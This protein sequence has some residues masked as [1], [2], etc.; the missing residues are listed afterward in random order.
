[1]SYIFRLHNEGNNALNDWGNSSK[2]AKN[3]ID[4]IQDPNGESA[5]REITSI[6]SP[7]ARIDLVKTAFGKVAAMGVDG[8]TIYHKM[9][10]D[11]LDV[12]Q[13]F[14]EFDKYADQLEILVWDKQND[15]EELLNSPYPEHQQLGKTYDIFLKQDGNIYNFDQ[16]DRMYLLNFKNGP[17]MTNIIGATSPATLFF[18]S[19]ND[20]SYV[21]NA[22]RLS[23]ND[24]PFDDEWRPLYQ[25]DLEYQKFWYLMQK[26][27]PNFA[28]LFPE[29]NNYLDKSFQK[30]TQQEQQI[31][32]AIQPNDLANYSD[33]TVNGSAGNIVYLINGISMKQK[34]QNTGNIEQQSGFV[35]DSDYRI[36]GKKPLVLPIDIY[37]KPTFYISAP[38]DRNTVVPKFDS[39]PVGD[40]QLPDSDKYPYL[41]I[42]DFLSDTIVRMPYE[43]NKERFFDGNIDKP[44]GNG[45]LLPLTPLFFQCFTVQQLSGTLKN[46]KK[47]FELQSNAGGVTAILRIPVKSDII[48]YH[49]TYFE[50][51][52]PDIVNNDGALREKKFGLGILPLVRFADNINKHYRIALFDKGRNDV[53]LTCWDGVNDQI[54][55]EAHIVREPKDLDD[56]ICSYESY[57]INANF[58]RIAVKVGDYE[59]FIIPK[60]K[61]ESGNTKFT[62]AV[63]FGTTNTHIEYCSEKNYNP[64]SFDMLAGEKQLHRLHTEYPD[65][66]IRRGFEDNF[67]PEVIADNTEYSFPMRTAFSEHKKADYNA[68]L[69][70]M[71]DGNIPFLYEKE[72]FPEDYNNA[73]TNL[74]WDS[75]I[76][77]LIEL[78][79]GSVFILLRNKVLLNGGNL[80]ATKIIWFYPA[81]MNEG[82][83]TKL[84]KTWKEL[85]KKYFGDDLDNV[86]CMSESS[87]PYHY[88]SKKQGAKSD[89]VTID[90]GGGTT[91]V[92]VVESKI[93][94]MLL[95]FRYA[96]NAIFGDAYNWDSDNNG[97]VKRY[98]NKFL[99]VLRTNGFLELEQAFAQIENRKSSPDITAFLFA[100]AAN[101]KIKGNKSLDFLD[102]LSADDQ[103]RYVFILF[104]ASIIYFIAKSMKN[105]GLNKPLTLAFSGN[106][107][108][109]LRI[110]SDDKKIIARFAKLIFDGVYGNDSGALDVIMEDNP[111]KATCKGGI[112]EPKSQE[113]DRIEGVKYTLIGNDFDTI[114]DEKVRYSNITSE[115]QKQ[116]VEQVSQFMDF[117]FQLHEDNNDFFTNKLSADESILRFVRDICSDQSELRESLKAGMDHKYEEMFGSV[118]DPFNSAEALEK[119]KDKKVE[120]TLFFYP[121]VGIL[122]K[123]AREISDNFN[124]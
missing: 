78:Y 96:S 57:V 100:L 63:D 17:A 25:R 114:P 80:G 73:K 55:E 121:L 1:M 83:I 84:N 118:I 51:V 82:K 59:A 74:K 91:D 6:P 27:T 116:I 18:T 2:Y 19:G 122:N 8:Q 103:L 37:T 42:S 108:K 4:Q 22:I 50:G 90:V 101:K 97:F 87:A 68:V 76:E 117:M 102:R 79:L 46:G 107:A 24:R 77:K 113:P 47:M 54:V 7:F 23:G 11:T 92:Y 64:V 28:R 3:V 10:S 36:N 39:T 52:S 99:D 124:N 48:E 32:R 20:L 62:F 111:K 69:H 26:I 30:L 70:A 86:I 61:G 45:Y 53:R 110:V 56:N 71:A 43:I 89:V 119:L 34:V 29:I 75:K 49:R 15:L 38:W 106:G 21:S 60:F 88:Y 112:L 40:R 31:I 93:P 58:D 123:L 9:I 33:V 115:T 94:K 104:Y 41:T 120:E 72:K 85:Y 44:N 16:M 109:T 95:S 98:K 67:I 12:G 105:K 81:S 66:D 13:L 5:K 14:F 65:A 35:M